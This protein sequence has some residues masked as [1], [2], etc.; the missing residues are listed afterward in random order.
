MSIDFEVKESEIINGVWIFIPS[1]SS[2][3]RGNI[4]T[5][6]I[7]SEIETLLPE[8]LH[9]KHDKFSESKHNVLRGIHGDS[10]SWKLVTCV[11]GEI[12]QVV[13]DMREDSPT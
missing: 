7:K 5:S 9:F 8:G 11:Y 1:I 6:F 2:D 12:S 10:K 13:V 3:N 4:W